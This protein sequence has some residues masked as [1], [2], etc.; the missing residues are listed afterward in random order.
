[1]AN[2]KSLSSKIAK[3]QA[4]SASALDLFSV[5]KRNLETNNVELDAVLNGVDDE[6]LLLTEIKQTS[7]TQRRRN[8]AAIN[9][10]NTIL[11]E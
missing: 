3:I 5:A 1:M 9:G 6:I 4:K 10:I 11:G 7:A 8:E 2:S